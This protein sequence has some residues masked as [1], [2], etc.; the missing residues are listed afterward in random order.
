MR[1]WWSR[2]Q[3]STARTTTS[4]SA[5]GDHCGAARD[6]LRG[7]RRGP[8]GLAVSAALAVRGVDN[9][10]LE[11]GQ[12]GE[13][14]R[15]PAGWSCPSPLICIWRVWLGRVVTDAIQIADFRVVRDRFPQGG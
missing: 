11:R 4:A 13:T 9:V 14:W 10:V 2:K 6:G 3:W 1:T 8:A 15:T 7:R 5:T 12:A